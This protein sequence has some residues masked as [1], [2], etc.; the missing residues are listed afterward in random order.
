MSNTP[1]FVGISNDDKD[2]KRNRGDDAGRGKVQRLHDDAS[3]SD[4]IE[5]PDEETDSDDDYDFSAV[6]PASPR[7]TGADVVMTIPVT[8]AIDAGTTHL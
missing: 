1:S 7:D 5:G 6:P 3:N 8:I 4:V 2:C